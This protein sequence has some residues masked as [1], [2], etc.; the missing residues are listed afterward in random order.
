MDEFQMNIIY[1][2]QVFM[3]SNLH[4]SGRDPGLISD[5]CFDQIS[6]FKWYLIFWSWC[7]QPAQQIRNYRR[8]RAA[9][10][11]EE[12]FTILV[13][14]VSTQFSHLS[15]AGRSWPKSNSTSFYQLGKTCLVSPG[16]SVSE[17]HN[18]GLPCHVR[19]GDLENVKVAQFKLHNS[20]CNI[21]TQQF[22]LSPSH[23]SPSSPSC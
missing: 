16:W 6:T 4:Q 15:Q 10:S 17:E 14:H 13:F 12:Y 7:P 18:K 20:S 5:T 23:P 9:E 22:S 11:D 21:Y 2:N 3:S 8:G 1:T 19:C